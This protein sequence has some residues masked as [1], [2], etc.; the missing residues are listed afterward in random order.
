MIR[1]TLK[2]IEPR[3]PRARFIFKDLP[4]VKI[5]PWA[6]TASLAARCVYQQNPDAFWKVHDAI[7]DNQDAITSENAW[8]K[9][10]TFATQ[11]GVQPDSFRACMISP[12][13]KRAVE[14]N[15]ADARALKIGSTPTI[16]VNGRPLLGGPSDSLEQYI[17]YEL[18]AHPQK[19]QL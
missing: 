19:P 18:A 8:D 5:H 17:T 7:F 9:M 4:L 11:A 16:F 15:M 3:Y 2:A 14:A 13:A 6:M 10:L 12:E 1:K